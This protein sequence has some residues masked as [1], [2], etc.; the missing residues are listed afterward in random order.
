MLTQCIGGVD[1]RARLKPFI[2]T[3][4]LKPEDELLICSD[5]LTD[6]LTDQ[7][8]ESF[9]GS[10]PSD[11]SAALV[12]AALDAGGKDNVSVVVIGAV[13]S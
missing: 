4:D 10:A 9:W 3:I 11:T 1:R 12:R 7:Q 5:G 8:I 13:G 2:A 6:M